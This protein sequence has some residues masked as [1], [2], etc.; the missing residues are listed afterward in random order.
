MGASAKFTLSRAYI[1]VLP[2]ATP[3]CLLLRERRGLSDGDL[4]KLGISDVALAKQRQGSGRGEGVFEAQKLRALLL[5]LV[6]TVEPA[7]PA[8]LS[9]VGKALF[10]DF[11][12]I[13]GYPNVRSREGQR[14]QRVWGGG[15]DRGGECENWNRGVVEHLHTLLAHRIRNPSQP[16]FV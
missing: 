13:E 9:G 3:P 11:E 16:S 15:R 1:L 6:C 12:Y 5:G 10:E 2:G 8:P 7:K 14:K 4:K